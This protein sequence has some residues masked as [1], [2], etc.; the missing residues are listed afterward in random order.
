MAS[1]IC[2]RC[3]KS[4]QGNLGDS[5]CPSCRAN[6]SY[7]PPSLLNQD[8][9]RKREAVRNYVRDHQGISDREVAANMNVSKKFIKGMMES[10]FFEDKSGVGKKR[11]YQCAKC[12]K[13]ITAGTYCRECLAYLRGAAKAQG[14]RRDAMK[15][16]V[17]EEKKS[18]QSEN[19]ILVVDKDELTANMVK[20]I[21][22]KGLQDYTVSIVNSLIKAI[23]VLRSMNVKL[24]LVDDLVDADYDGLKILENIRND[25]NTKST[26]VVVM[27]ATPRKDKIARALSMGAL[28]YITKPFAPQDLMNRITK[29]LNAKTAEFTRQSFKILLIDDQ[30]LDARREKAILENKL[31]VEVTVAQSGVEGLYILGEKE[32]DLVMTNLDMPFMSGMEILSFIRRDE[33]MRKISVIMMTDVDEASEADSMSAIKGYVKKPEFSAVGLSMIENALKSRIR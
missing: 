24:V 33:K 14:E 16:M 21:L 6:S 1:R 15:R 30:P 18:I 27:S 9:L 3:G 28:N 17:T 10:G 31:P 29:A 13:M 5:I 4:F 11:R 32:V 23:N 25:T 8:E 20:F 22:E 2:A 26:P 7:A 19:I 12:G